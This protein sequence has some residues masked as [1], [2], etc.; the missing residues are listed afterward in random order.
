MLLDI[1]GDMNA[2]KKTMNELKKLS[3][4]EKAREEEM[5]EDENNV[6]ILYKKSYADLEKENAELKEY[7]EKLSEQHA[8]EWQKQQEVITELK[9]Q[10]E[11]MKNF[12]FEEIDFCFYCPLTDTCINNEGTCPYANITEEEQKKLLSKWISK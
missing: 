4:E 2:I 6:G 9:A 10:I 5:R 8:D 11:K 1:Q 3:D 12:I 7:A